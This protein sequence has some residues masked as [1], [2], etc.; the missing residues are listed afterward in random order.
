M[1][2][3]TRPDEPEE[4]PSVNR[5]KGLS[6]DRR[7]L[8]E[9]MM[10]KEASEKQESGPENTQNPFTNPGINSERASETSTGTDSG[11]GPNPFG[12]P[13]EPPN[14]DNNNSFGGNWNPGGF[15]NPFA[16]MG[17][18][19]MNP[20]MFFNPG[21]GFFSQMGKKFF[22]GFDPTQF[23]GM[24]GGMPPNFN[25]HEAWGNGD[26]AGQQTKTP[27]NEPSSSLV[28]I[29]PTG[30]RPPFFCV[31]A[32]IGSVFPYHNLAL[33]MEKDQ[34][35]YGLQS[36]GF[37]KNEASGKTIEGMATEYIA[38]IKEVQ[39]R[40]PYYLSGYSFGGWVAW[41]MATQLLA[42]GEKI[43]LLAIFGTL[44]PSMSNPYAEKM[45]F[46]KQ[47]FE[48]FTNLVLNSLMA[49]KP[50]MNPGAFLDTLLNNPN[51]SPAVRKVLIHIRSQL[52]YTAKPTPIEADLFLTQEL[53]E[54]FSFDL[55]MGWDKL[56]SKVETHFVSGNHINT[57]H[58]PHVKDLA[59]ELTAC[60]KQA[61]AN[62]T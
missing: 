52:K 12:G 47:Y 27:P 48:D 2:E 45:K 33:C 11:A 15:T 34:P 36:T 21:M 13:G 42:A 22:P 25:P 49:D 40:G 54:F 8:F 19:G 62:H 35:F 38:A 20:N 43:N 14:M 53:Q 39:P 30:S 28:A 46:A 31:H 16:G 18:S 26:S 9:A 7:K 3:E 17:Q 44:A 37:D 56:C 10:E 6:E 57:F 51:V 23:G 29:K 4:K 55:S 32:L 58:D 60:L 61:Q 59:K 41:E 24:P 5:K 50:R 1:V